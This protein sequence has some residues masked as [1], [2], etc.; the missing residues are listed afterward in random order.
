MT[1]IYLCIDSGDRIIDI[2]TTDYEMV[3]P[4]R[5]PWDIA[6]FTL[7][8]DKYNKITGLVEPITPEPETIFTKLKFRQKFTLEE[9]SG[10]YTAEST[11]V[12]IKIFL[13]DL[14]ASEFIDLADVNTQN[15][16]G[17]LFNAGYITYERMLEILG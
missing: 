2:M 4:E 9:L 6:D 1:K 13:D 11:D 8:G 12:I 7:I 3:H 14:S 17:Y 10:I 15:G 5:I 16:I